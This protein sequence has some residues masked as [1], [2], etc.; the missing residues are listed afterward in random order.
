MLSFLGEEQPQDDSPEH[1]LATAAA[2]D[3]EEQNTMDVEADQ[4]FLLNDQSTT[5]RL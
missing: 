1:N 4:R 5:E 2:D 3:A